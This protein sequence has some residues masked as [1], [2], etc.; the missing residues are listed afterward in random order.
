MTELLVCELIK[1]DERHK[2]KTRGGNR[3]F[4]QDSG[5]TPA[6]ENW[7]QERETEG[8]ERYRYRYFY[9]EGPKSIY[10]FMTIRCND[11]S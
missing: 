2:H 5:T 11:R 1:V 4:L 8:E 10:I 9:V 3:F 7:K 6:T